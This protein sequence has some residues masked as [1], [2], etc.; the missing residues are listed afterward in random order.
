MATIAEL[1]CIFVLLAHASFA[2][3]GTNSLL[4]CAAPD[5]TSLL[6]VTQEMPK[7]S[8]R[9]SLVSTQSLSQDSLRGQEKKPTHQNSLGQE[10]PVELL[11]AG[12]PRLGQLLPGVAAA[13]QI[14]GG[15]HSAR[16]AKNVFEGAK[17]V[18]PMS[19]IGEA[20]GRGISG[21]VRSPAGMVIGTG[22]GV[23]AS[24][25]PDGPLKQAAGV[26]KDVTTGEIPN[27]VGKMNE[28][29]IQ[30]PAIRDGVDVANQYQEVKGMSKAVISPHRWA[31]DKIAG[32]IRG[33]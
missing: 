30:S 17:K 1:A 13:T 22:A 9:E 14:G 27:A 18:S 28:A 12:P 8:N 21:A 33:E 11:R 15:E 5:T 25:L 3:D 2:L 6:Q 7:R 32:H 4:S 31:A 10:A 16:I 23:G 26:V 29:T 19:K 24:S 20:A